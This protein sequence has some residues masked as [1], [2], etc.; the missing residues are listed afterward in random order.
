MK[1]ARLELQRVDEYN[2]QLIND[3]LDDTVRQLE[4]RIATLYNRV[5]G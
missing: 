4:Q 1:S 3:C 5:E 2:D